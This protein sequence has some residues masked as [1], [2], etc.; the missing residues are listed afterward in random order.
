M[1]VVAIVVSPIIV[2][3]VTT[4]MILVLV[5]SVASGRT[6]VVFP[7][8]SSAPST[9]ASLVA[10]TFAFCNVDSQRSVLKESPVELECLFQRVLIVELDVAK[11]LELIRLLVTHKAHGAHFQVLKHI[12]DIALHDAV[13]QVADIRCEW[14]FIRDWSVS[15]A[16][17]AVVAIS[18]S[19]RQDRCF[20]A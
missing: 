5:T 19:A 15:T 20:S 1:M 7:T 16:T 10:I 12:V 18:S 2:A 8:T 13:G 6:S 17:A 3:P 11:S 14:G 9:T 4:S